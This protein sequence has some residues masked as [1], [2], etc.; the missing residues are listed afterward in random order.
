MEIRQRGTSEVVAWL[1][2][3][4][5]NGLI[6]GSRAHVVRVSGEILK[7]NL[8][9]VGSGPQQMPAQLWNNPAYPEW[10]LPVRIKLTG[11]EVGASEPVTVRL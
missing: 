11:G 3:A 9:S 5:A 7:G 10:G 6:A 4:A 1:P 2:Y 8:L